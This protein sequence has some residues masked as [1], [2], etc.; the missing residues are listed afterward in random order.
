M[1]EE[2]DQEGQPHLVPLTVPAQALV[3]SGLLTGA[4]G[5]YLSLGY[6]TWFA[7]DMTAGRGFVAVAVAVMSDGSA[8]G[9]AAAAVVVAVAEAAAVSL[10]ASGLPTE[11]LGAIPYLLPALVLTLHALRRQHRLARHP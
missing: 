6:V 11:L 3:L 7:V 8:W 9:T 5:A 2:Q 4:A 10:G 1:K